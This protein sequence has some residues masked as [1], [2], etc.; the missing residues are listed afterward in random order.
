LICGFC[1]ASN[2]RDLSIDRDG[3]RI[4]PRGAVFFGKKHIPLSPPQRE[5]FY[6]LAR[7]EHDVTHDV[8]LN[9][10]GSNDTQV[11]TVQG[12]IGDIRR[13]LRAL[14]VPSPIISVIGTGYRWLSPD[15]ISVVHR[16][17]GRWHQGS[18]ARYLM[19]AK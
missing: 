11:H 10:V 2:N 15:K 7:I 17:A 16:N 8:L 4:D 3:F 6:T 9:R 12:Y 14:A 13:I 1:G 5:I 19:T 18:T